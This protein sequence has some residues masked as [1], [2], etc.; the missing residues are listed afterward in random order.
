M[1][2][3]CGSPMLHE[4]VN[5]AEVARC[6]SP[7]CKHYRKRFQRPTVELRQVGH[8]SVAEQRQR[9]DEFDKRL[10]GVVLGPPY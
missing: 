3:E 6:C 7:E 1:K 4:S 9:Q 2:C 8:F 5:S 10:Y